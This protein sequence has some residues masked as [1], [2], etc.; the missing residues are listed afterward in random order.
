[1]IAEGFKQILA[2]GMDTGI[3]FKQLL[4]A[5][6]AQASGPSPSAPAQAAAAT[7]APQAAAAPEPE[8]VEEAV[9]M[10]GLFD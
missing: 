3:Q 10:G 5:Q 1:M 8:P 6:N 2:I 7:K 9:S 4:D